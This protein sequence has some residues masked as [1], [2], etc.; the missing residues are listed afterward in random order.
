MPRRA[1]LRFTSRDRAP[2]HQTKVVSRSNM[3]AVGSKTI[4]K[5]I[6]VLQLP[7]RLNRLHLVVGLHVKFD[8]SDS[9][10]PMS[11]PHKSGRRRLHSSLAERAQRLSHMFCVKR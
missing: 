5:A 1:R 9:Q 7:I 10:L 2:P 4:A 3:L 6:M 11:L 8:A